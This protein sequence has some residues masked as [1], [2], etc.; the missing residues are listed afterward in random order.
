MLERTARPLR[1]LWNG[2]AGAMD[3]IFSALGRPGKLLQDFL[4]GTWLGHTLHAAIVDVVVGASTA[5]L[6]LDVLRVAFGVVGLEDA[7]TWVLV[8]AVLSAAGS[9]V[10]G[11]TDFKDTAPSATDRDVAGLHGLT[12]IAGTALLGVSL[13]LRVGGSHDAAFW[14]LLVGYG[15]IS[16]GAYIGGHVVYKYGYMVNRNAFN[17][18]KRAKEFTPVVAL[19]DLPEGAPTKVAF[20]STAVMM[21][22]RGDVVH[23][24]K[25]TCSHAAGPLSEGKLDG[26]TITCPWHYSTFRLTD[27]GVVHGPASSRQPSYVARVTAGMVEL[28]G[29][30]G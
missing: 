25:E 1:G 26:D 12:N 20:G 22:R 18:G 9:I 14:V 5:A 8:L 2:T 24:L 17:R 30:H 29:P 15:V 6:L 3:A 4:N 23:A 10:T 19:V 13:G 16:V 7:T 11:L 28:Q 27:G 21:V